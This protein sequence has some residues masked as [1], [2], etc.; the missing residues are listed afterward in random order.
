MN[1]VEELL[2]AG[3]TKVPP[4]LAEHVLRVADE[5]TRLADVH[6]VD[7]DS[8]RIAALA[9]DILRAHAPDRLLAIAEEQG[10]AMDP[11][12]RMEPVLMHG[13]LAVPILQ[14]QYKLMDADVLG[15]VALHTTAGPGM[16][17]LQKL[18]FVADKIDPHKMNGRAPALRVADLAETDLD[19]ALLAYLDY[20]V[21]T[22]LERGWPLHPNTIA[23]R[24][25]LL[26]ER[27]GQPAAK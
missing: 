14:E 16:S 19:A 5:A 9:H 10:F 13:P 6:G 24:N 8:A 2:R 17:R 18:L 4:G 23:A 22:A 12:D 26:R 21:T 25:E 7:R 15:A 11:A 27:R 20:Q 3:L 1:D